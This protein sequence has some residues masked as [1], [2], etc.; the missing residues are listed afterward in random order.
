MKGE[1]VTRRKQNPL[2]AGD[3]NPFLSGGEN[4]TLFLCFFGGG[5]E[6]FFRDG[7]VAGPK[8]GGSLGTLLR[9]LA[10][11]EF[12]QSSDAKLDVAVGRA[13]AIAAVSSIPRSERVAGIGLLPVV[14]SWLPPPHGKQIVHHGCK[15]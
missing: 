5:E 6:W 3:E 8:T 11:Q 4:E 10:R 1:K 12:F 13:V 2:H 7:S 9:C 14:L 15:Y